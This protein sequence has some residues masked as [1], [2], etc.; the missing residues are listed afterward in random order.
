MSIATTQTFGRSRIA[1]T[2]TFAAHALVAGSV[3]PWIPRLKAESTLDAA[4]LGLALTGYAV[5]L[6]LG[7]RLAGPALQ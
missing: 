3:G 1:V 2:A 6:V 5:G 7:T 4:G